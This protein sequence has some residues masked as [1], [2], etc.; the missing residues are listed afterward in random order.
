MLDWSSSNMKLLFDAGYQA[1][2]AFCDKH[3][4][5]LESAAAPATPSRARS[6]PIEMAV[7]AD[8]PVGAEE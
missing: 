6:A 8:S 5:L 4:A 2:L 3:P 1:G 7:E